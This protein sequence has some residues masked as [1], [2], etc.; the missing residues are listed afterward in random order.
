MA[1]IVNVQS[2]ATAIV[3]AIIFA[4]VKLFRDVDQIKTAQKYEIDA[5]KVEVKPVI[6]WFEKTSLDALRIATNPTSE[7]LTELADRYIAIVRGQ[8]AQPL[9]TQEKQELIDGLREVMNDKK[10]FEAKRQSASMSLRF[11][12]TREGLTAKAAKH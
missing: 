11:I 2:I 9:S 3:I 8:H 5:L 4:F 10:Q 7:R 12:E 6:T 1:E